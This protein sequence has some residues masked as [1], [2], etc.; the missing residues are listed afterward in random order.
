MHDLGR[1]VQRGIQGKA[2][3]PPA[4][5]E[6]A[7]RGMHVYPGST[8]LIAGVAGTYKSM[9]V[10]NAIVNMGVPTLVFSTDSDDLTVASRLL[11]LATGRPTDQT[12]L[13]ALQQ[14]EQA[15]Q[16][17]STKYGFI[18]WSFVSDPDGDAVWNHVFAYGTRY[19]RWPRLI[20]VD[21]V[22][23]VAFETA[24]TE[25]A[26]LR[27]AMKQFNIL[28]RETNA[29]VI[30]VHHVTEGTKTTDMFPCPSR[31]DIMGK[32]VRHPVMVVTC[33]KDSRGDA[34]VAAVKLR[35]SKADA[36]GKD[37][38]RMFVNPDTSQVTDWDEYS[39]LHAANF[40]VP[41]PVLARSWGE[42]HP[43]NEED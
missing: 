1:I 15:A 27:V 11:G 7:R 23:D 31:N 20:V 28:A 16:L 39:H 14:P 5:P 18:K 2:P 38:F 36:S 4:Y 10:Q 3:L 12:R 9:I 6:W 17:L 26:A 40:R 24:E 41:T 34:H 33:G 21:I 43:H 37:S 25:W 30:L 35:H 8:H 42:A 19:G 22:T 32:D 13:M 29:A